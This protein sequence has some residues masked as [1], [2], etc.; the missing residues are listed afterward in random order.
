[1]FNQTTFFAIVI[2]LFHIF[3]I[4]LCLRLLYFASENLFD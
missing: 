3:I 1:M 4:I 2:I